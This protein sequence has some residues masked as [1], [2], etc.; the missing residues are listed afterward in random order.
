MATP[1]VIV[2]P[3]CALGAGLVEP[4]CPVCSG[5]GIVPLGPIAEAPRVVALAV[6]AGLHP[7]ELP[8]GSRFDVDDVG[9]RALA[10]AGE[11]FLV[12]PPH[13]FDPALW[14]RERL[15]EVELGLRQAAGYAG[16][17]GQPAIDELARA[18]A[19]RRR[20]A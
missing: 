18:R 17:T 20:H 4:S 16:P 6:Q 11:G 9:T 3:Q 8:T 13:D 15:G 7:A 10:L 14:R 19:R 12:I 2:C 1:D 5:F